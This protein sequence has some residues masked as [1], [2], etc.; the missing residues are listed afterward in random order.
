MSVRTICHWH[1][2]FPTSNSRPPRV[3]IKFLLLNT[4]QN[5]FG[6]ETPSQSDQFHRDLFNSAIC[7][8]SHQLSWSPP[9]IWKLRNSSL[10]SFQEQHQMAH[11]QSGLWKTLQT[12]WV[13]GAEP[14]YRKSSRQKK[15][16]NGL[17]RLVQKVVWAATP[18]VVR[19]LAQQSKWL[20]A[21]RH[22]FDS[23]Q[24]TIRHRFSAFWLRSKCSI[25]SYQLNIW[26]EG[27]VPS[28][29]LN[30]FLNGDGE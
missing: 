24:K 17:C 4:T 11:Q 1:L 6:F 3:S 30:L 16:P 14:R 21:F 15:S 13:Q 18:R 27:H 26:Y 20:H 25:C 29:I 10:C 12:A 8:Q 23:A 2:P 9:K 7:V 19:P 5:D 28:S 22:V